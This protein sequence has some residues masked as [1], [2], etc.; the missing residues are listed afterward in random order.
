VDTPTLRSDDAAG[1]AG[2]RE[3]HLMLVDDGRLAMREDPDL[4]ETL[5]CIR[6]GAC[7]NVRANVQ[8]VGGHAFG[9]ET[10]SGGIATGRV[11]GNRR[12]SS[13]DLCTGCPRC[14]EARPVGIDIPWITTVVRDRMNRGAE[15]RFDWLVEGLAPEADPGGIDP[16]ERL[17]GDF[18][19]LA[20]P[21][22]ALA[23]ASN[24]VADT[25]PVR[26]AMD[27]L[28]GVDQR[29]K[30][31]TFARQSLLEW[32]DDTDL[33]VANARRKAVLCPDVYTD[34]VDVERGKAA[35]RTLTAFGVDLVVPDVGGSGRA[36]LSQGMVATA[37]QR[38]DALRTA[39]AP[40]VD[41][42]RDVVVVVV[43]IVIVVV[44]PSDLAMFR[45]DYRTLALEA[46][47]LLADRSFEA[48]E[49]VY[50]LLADGADPGVPAGP[51][52]GAA[53]TDGRIASHSHCQQRTL[54]IEEHTVAVL[55]RLG[56]DVA[57]SEA[58][59]CG[60]AGGLRLRERVLR[61]RRR[62][63]RAPGRRAPVPG[64]DPESSRAVPPVSISSRRSSTGP[65]D[66]RSTSSRP[67]RDRPAGVAPGPDSGSEI[68]V[69]H[70]VIAGPAAQ[71][72]QRHPVHEDEA[73]H[74]HHHEDAGD[75][76]E[77]LV[78]AAENG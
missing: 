4:K 34:H 78:A 46:S 74:H 36:P 50:G 12:R 69:G 1:G 72:A 21:G 71:R 70:D 43:I 28:V 19:T 56:Y 44:E 65:P 22:S 10:Y 42:G 29:R 30:L 3:F 32:T 37:R 2:D 73:D 47:D 77:Q 33:R 62:R 25:G 39:L 52:F 58:E 9:G 18:E 54:G 38:A 45:R 53:A 35:V 75:A 15:A 11:V 66:T 23:P 31:S 17:F 60:V 14:T 59:C 48:V 68:R 27:R 40:H 67:S 20:R 76:D 55:E 61:P 57:T 49:Y 26:A 51:D 64:I 16:D 41:V 5:Y 63:R 6:C 24:W 8:S 13:T 7:S